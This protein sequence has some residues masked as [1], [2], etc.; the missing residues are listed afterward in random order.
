MKGYYI[1]ALLLIFLVN[2][3]SASDQE[4]AI[5]CG[6][7]DQLIITCPVGEDQLFF[8]GEEPETTNVSEI[9][10]GNRIFFFDS[11]YMLVIIIV[12]ILVI[13]LIALLLYLVFSK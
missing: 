5:P 6:G 8:M 11:G 1:I 10:T 3:V 4:I 12:S 2:F 7:D 9:K 13:L